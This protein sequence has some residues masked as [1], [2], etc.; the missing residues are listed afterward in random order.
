MK[1]Y[2]KLVAI[3]MSVL[4]VV[5]LL[6]GFYNSSVKA[7][8]KVYTIKV[9]NYFAEDHPQNIA[10]RE[11]FKAIVEKETN[12]KV[13]VQIYPNSSLGG[14]EQ[15]IDGVKRGNIEMAVA[16]LLVSRDV[17][18][19][20]MLEMP[21]LFRD[22]DHAQKVLNGPIGEQLAKETISKMGVRVLAWT[23][24]G[25]RVISSSKPIN[26]F[27]DFKGFRL[28]VPNN[29]IFIEM[30]KALGANPVP[31][32]ISE[33]FTALEQRVVDGQENPYATLR[34]SGFYEVQKYVVD[35]RHIFSPN[36]YIINERFWKSLPAKYQQIILKAARESAAYEWK[37]LKESEQKDIEFLQ[38]KGLKI[39]FPDKTFKQKLI[40]SQKRVQEWVYKNYPGSR[41]LAKK[42][43]AVK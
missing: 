36:L 37:L 13:K 4:F 16:G 31:M 38:Q 27:E 7:S 2:Y 32:P 6:T 22:Y 8:G 42:I 35:T 26:K 21:Y 39:V 17:K 15:F 40:A 14:E 10:L 43:M 18:I 25:F 34:A 23:A 5:S 30:A 41:E 12:G 9:A 20:G 11:K 28:R 33:V 1:K 24:N 3:I 19:I 29:P